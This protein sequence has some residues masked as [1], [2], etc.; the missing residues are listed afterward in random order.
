MIQHGVLPRL[1]SLLTDSSQSCDVQKEAIIVLT[2]LAKGS[3]ENAAALVREGITP[4]LLSKSKSPL[5]SV[6]EAAVKCLKTVSS[7][8]PDHHLAMIFSE[9]GMTD[10]LVNLIPRSIVTR[11]A[12]TSILAIAC[13]STEDQS[14]LLKRGILQHLAPILNQPAISPAVLAALDCLYHVCKNHC[15][16]SDQAVNTR[17]LIGSLTNLL[18]RMNSAPCQLA[19]AK[20]VSAWHNVSAIKDPALV[21]KAVSVLISLCK[22]NQLNE[23]RINAAR[24]LSR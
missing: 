4:V 24:T 16:A 8:A 21:R 13:R 2:S 12:V 1:L 23:I 10:H 14:S 18:S 7:H 17:G 20:V 15:H 5:P 19:A 22:D 6:V 9:P 3:P 11:E